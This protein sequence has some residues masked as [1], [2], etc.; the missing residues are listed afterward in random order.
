M[1]KRLLKK[2]RNSWDAFHS[3]ELIYRLQIDRFGGFDVA[4]RSGT[5]DEKV[6]GHSFD[7]DIFFTG[8]PECELK[9]DD[10]VLDI[11]AH[12]GT[13]S[14]LAASKV[15]DGHVYAIEASG[16]TFNY[17]RVNASLNRLDN[18]TPCLLALTDKKGTVRLH[19]D[20]GNWGHS[21]M[22]EMSSKFEEV[23]ADTLEN[24][25]NQHSIQECAFAKFNCEGA[26]FPILVNSSEAT[27]RRI[28]MM[29]VLYHEDLATGYTLPG[30]QQKLS[31]CGF[32]VEL[33]NTRPSGVRG[34]LVA[35]RQ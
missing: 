5:A 30:L 2:L 10:V 25:L 31:D 7:N 33:R 21:I 27:L 1:K 17:L 32:A 3:G 22:K 23:P 4:Y 26:E 28:R 24:F 35:T 14:L 34:W 19:H 11:G 15:P 29:L 6:I 8:V 12:I 13:F 20:R 16:E 9:T 18:V